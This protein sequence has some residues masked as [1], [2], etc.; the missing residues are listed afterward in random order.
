M[1]RDQDAGPASLRGPLNQVTPCWRPPGC[2]SPSLLH[3]HCIWA[4]A[5]LLTPDALNEP[6][7]PGGLCVARAQWRA[8]C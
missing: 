3:H 4:T 8:F 6:T 5:L 7:V 1:L 2:D